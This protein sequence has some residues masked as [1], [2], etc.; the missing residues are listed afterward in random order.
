M[1]GG[2]EQKILT[3]LRE[4][5]LFEIASRTHAKWKDDLE[6]KYPRGSRGGL[7][8]IVR[9]ARKT[10][11]KI[12]SFGPEA[13]VDD[14]LPHFVYAAERW[15]QV[16]D[17]DVARSRPYLRYVCACLPDSRPAHLEKLGLVFP[18]DHH[19]WDVWYPLNGLGCMCTVM[20]VSEDLLLRRGWRI[21]KISRFEFEAPDE[22]F[23]FNIGKSV[24]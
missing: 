19:F 23:D 11:D 13:L 22:G 4:R 15:K 10:Q 7:N 18:V 24:S 8:P 16:T 9:S 2:L 1:T 3:I 14:L 20:S 12:V 17:P 5:R 6:A 21:S